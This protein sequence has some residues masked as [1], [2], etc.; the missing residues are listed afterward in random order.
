MAVLESLKRFATGKSSSERVAERNLNISIKREANEAA[1][2]VRRQQAIRFAE[3]RERVAFK[4]KIEQLNKPK[5]TFTG[6]YNDTSRAI[7]LG[8]SSI[9]GERVPARVSPVNK[10]IKRRKR[11]SN[12]RK[13]TKQQVRV[14]FVTRPQQ[15][16]FRVI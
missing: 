3:E 5:P 2:V 8:I 4:R 9:A 16:R 7:G 11:Q 15:Q 10:I 6:Y 13:R 1:A 14:R 12:R